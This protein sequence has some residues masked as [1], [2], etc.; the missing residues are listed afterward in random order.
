MTDLV[1]AGS[2]QVTDENILKDPSIYLPHNVEAEQGLLGALL[3]NNEVYDKIS[4]LLHSQHFFDPVH[5][6]IYEVAIE[7]ISRNSLASPVTLKT[8]F[9]NDPGLKELGGVSYLA[10]LAASA[11]SLFGAVDYAK[12]I[13]ELALRRNLINLGREISEKALSEDVEDSPEEQ[14][15]MA[16]AQL[17]S[18]AEKGAESTGFTPLL[19]ASKEAILIANKAYQQDGGISGVSTGLIDLD[20]K[21]GGLHSSDLLIIAGRPSM[22]KT[23]LATNMAFSIAK[24]L[25]KRKNEDGSEDI[26]QGG[27]VGFFSLEMSSAQLATRILSENSKVPS[28]KIRKGDLTEREFRSFIESAQ[29]IEKCPLY[30]DDTAALSISALAGRARRLKRMYGLDVLFIDYLQLI[31][32]SSSRDSRVNEISEITQGLKSIAKEL[33]IPVVALSQLSRQVEA[34][35]DKRPQLSDLRESGSIEQDADVVMFIFREEYYKEREKP[36]EHDVENFIK[37]Q[38]DMSRLHGRAELII[39]KQR[40]GPIGTVELSFQSK[41]TTFGNLAK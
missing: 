39:G 25:K 6:R 24:S 32:P 33:N 28:D 23:S 16:E 36:D 35:D 37:W 40:H 19:S 14:I 10:K 2:I 34:R 17:Y 4:Q 11:I 21:L 38:E 27:I 15:A 7:K 3:V 22:G 8:H 9:Q 31:R 41:F 5:Q 29:D 1:H 12:L 26:V 30:I 13:C 20:K 18:I